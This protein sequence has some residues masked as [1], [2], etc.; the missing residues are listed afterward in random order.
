MLNPIDYS[1]RSE[2]FRAR[3]KALEAA[4]KTEKQLDNLRMLLLFVWV[5]GALIVSWH[6]LTAKRLVIILASALAIRWAFMF[7][8]YL[9]WTRPTLAKINREFTWVEHFPPDS[10][11]DRTPSPNDAQ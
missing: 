2:M 11:A 5:L 6:D 3:A 7:V 9:A 8:T 4:V 10:G 1:R